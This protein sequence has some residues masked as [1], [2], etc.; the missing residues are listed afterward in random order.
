MS[1]RAVSSYRIY[2]RTYLVYVDP[3][4]KVHFNEILIF[5]QRFIFRVIV[6][7]VRIRISIYLVRI[8]RIFFRYVFIFSLSLIN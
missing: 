2:V 3:K 4:Y 7:G 1:N 6:Q 5:V 8:I